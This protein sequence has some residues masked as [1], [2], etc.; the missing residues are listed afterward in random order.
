MD[1]AA[2]RRAASEAARE[3]D[4]ALEQGRFRDAEC[5][6]ASTKSSRYEDEG[7]AVHRSGG[8]DLM[9]AAVLDLMEDDT[10]G[11]SPPKCTCCNHRSDLC[12]MCLALLQY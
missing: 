6:I 12:L 8:D 3:G 11:G 10:V 1:P 4:Q 7:F 5:F 2:L 9:S